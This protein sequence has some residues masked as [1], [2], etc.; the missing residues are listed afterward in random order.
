M[1]KTK[2][3]K[4]KKQTLTKLVAVAVRKTTRFFNLAKNNISLGPSR[5][6]KMAN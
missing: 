4:T 1:K 2:T 6:A 3:T 5:T